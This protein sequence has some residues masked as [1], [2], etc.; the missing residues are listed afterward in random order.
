MKKRKLIGI[1]T[2]VVILAIVVFGAYNLFFKENDIQVDFNKAPDLVLKNLDEYHLS[3]TLG[4]ELGL[5]SPQNITIFN[6]NLL[7]ADSEN[8]RM[9]LCDLNGKLVKQFGKAGNGK[10]EFLQPHGIAIDNENN[11]YIL[12]SG[13]YRIQ[14]FDSNFNYIKE[15]PVKELKDKDVIM[16][17]IA[18]SSSKTIYFSVSTTIKEYGHIYVISA[19]DKVSELGEDLVGH[20]T[21]N[22]D[23]IYFVSGYNFY[24]KTGKEGVRS[25]TGKLL[26]IRDK[27]IQNTYE[28]PFKYNPNAIFIDNDKMY[29]ESGTFVT[30]DRF[31]MQGNYEGTI[32]KGDFNEQQMMSYSAIDK[33]KNIY[34][35][36]PQKNSIYKLTKN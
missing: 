13:N 10:G 14:I 2:G 6:D 5:K 1:I 32:F 9:L 27:K 28:L 18:V 22:K 25:G 31:R 24:K 30:L 26:V 12:D 11:I 17:D 29:I 23:N 7:V 19:D 33:D 8:N 21:M 3:A 4:T 20:L 35:S 34:I 15:I 16:A 36:D